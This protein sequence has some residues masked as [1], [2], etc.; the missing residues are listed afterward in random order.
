[1][2]T[3]IEISCRDP[4][5]S[6]DGRPFGLGAGTR[7]RSAG[8][9]LPSMVAGSFRTALAKAAEKDFSTANAELLRQ[10]SVCGLFPA[11][12]PKDGA[13]PTLYLPAPLDAVGAPEKT[14][15]RSRPEA[16]TDGEGCDFPHPNLLPVLLD[17]HGANPAFK[18]EPVPAWWPV[19]QYAQWLAADAIKFDQRFLGTPK[20]DARTHVKISSETGAAGDG[21]LFSTTSLVLSRLPVWGSKSENFGD[22]Y[23]P[24]SLISRAGAAT[25]PALQTAL[26][27]LN[28]ISPL[29]GE[30]RGAHWK[31]SAEN[32]NSLW[33]CPN[34]IA[35][36]LATAKRIRM[37]L[38]TPAIFTH[39]WRP[40]WLDNDLIGTVP[41]TTV[42]VK[43]V[44]YAGK[45]WHAVSGW[46]L[47]N[48][49]GQP[50]G[51]KPVRRLVPA[52]AVFFFECVGTSPTGLAGRWLESVADEEQ[53]QRDGFGLATWGI[54]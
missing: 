18:P 5:V 43:L 20:T 46:S 53:D 28:I 1:M 32:L 40:G 45:R 13:S 24:I 21:D 19:D 11:A 48:L 30:R 52:G 9:P 41:G 36:K 26:G 27:T 39:G 35:D 42:N 50:R 25:D 33:Q 51:P 44:A 12:V 14:I 29:G 49:P 8:W 38:A 47:A 7:M 22:R 15:I 2:S 16:L 17:S 31:A 10:V 37:V 6:R 3:L 23:R 4:I 54:W 34:I